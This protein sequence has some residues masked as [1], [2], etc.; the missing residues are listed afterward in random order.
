[1]KFPSLDVK[2]K[3]AVVA[4]ASRNIGRTLALG[5]ASAGADL[6]VCSR[7]VSDLETLAGEIRAMGRKAIVQR[8]DVTRLGDIRAMAEAAMGEYGRI[9]ILVNNAGVNINKSALE[10]T[11]EEWDRAMATNLKSYFF[12][13]QII[14]RH[15]VEQR[16]GKIININ[17]TFGLV[18]F[19]NRSAY[20]ASKGGIS[21]LTK[22][23]AIEWAPYNVNV[24]GIA[25]T[26]T[27][28]TINEELFANEEWRKEM[29]A[30]LPVGR[31]LEPR[32]LVG[33][34]VFLASD[35][36]NMVTGITLPVDGGWTA[37]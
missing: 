23:L 3:T 19:H 37:W 7:T 35:A 33:A 24:N 5:L 16:K 15:M 26:A 32:D 9:D 27:R 30:R 4:G 1:M 25:P 2:G 28:T 21:L 20:C 13:S 34:V 17:S 22:V 31:F 12:C 36:A 8:M 29:L 10:T 14:G 18:G 6:V 11:E